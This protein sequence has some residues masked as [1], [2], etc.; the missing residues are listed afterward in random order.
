MALPVTLLSGFLGSGKSTLLEHILR[1][2]EGLRCAVIVNDM[3]ELNIDA[4]LLSNKSIL[5][6][7]EKLIQMQNGCICCTLR[8]DLLEEVAQLA[9][10]GKF[11]YLVIE[12]TGISEPMQVAETF[13]FDEEA[14]NAVQ[15][16]NQTKGGAR[17]G[18]LEPLN[19]LARLDTC[20][21]VIDA[22]NFMSTFDCS[23]T[24][25]DV[26]KDA[27]EED[28]RNIIDLMCDQI[29]FSDVIILNKIDLITADE[30][31]KITKI[32]RQFN[33][34][35]EIISSAYSKVDLKKILNTN[36][37]DIEKA[38]KSAGWLKSL[39]EKHNPETLEYSIGHFIY[40]ARRPFHTKRIE[41]LMTNSFLLEQLDGSADQLA[42]KRNNKPAANGDDDSKD[43]EEEE[44]DDE[45]EF[46]IIGSNKKYE[47]KEVG[48]KEK[49]VEQK[50]KGVFAEILRSKG[51]VWLCTRNSVMGDW[52]Q[53]GIMLAFNCGG[54]WLSETPRDQWPIADDDVD[55]DDHLLSLEKDF[56]G[57]FGDKRQELVFIGIN[58]DRA[59]IEKALN[60]CLLTD[61][62]LA[63]F[64]ANGGHLDAEDNFEFWPSA[65][66]ILADDPDDDDDEEDEEDND[67]DHHHGHSHSHGHSHNH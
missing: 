35:A 38:S 36:K 34:T 19:K 42:A 7:E 66:D 18:V 10:G 62:E 30:Q 2:K 54:P 15:T 65:Q 27:D 67:D 3:A 31:D 58:Y 52:S 26:Q 53:A 6:R 61:E 49:R 63:Q 43:E 12:S 4:A 64:V 39:Q 47:V 48:W 37:F 55:A 13:T 23:Q 9:R 28:D 16:T 40:R 8:E 24:V 25:R 17:G 57:E 60:D 51:Y 33:S 44:E 20:V 32:L 59:A 41:D 45:N 29:E 22:A 5:Q 1:N 11:D 21:T 50:K 46:Q 56:Q 14:I